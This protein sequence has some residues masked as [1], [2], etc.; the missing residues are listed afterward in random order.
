MELKENIHQNIEDTFKVLDAIKEVKV[1]HF[2]KD[3]VLQQYQNKQEK[4]SKV[5][6]WFQPQLQLAALCLVLLLNASALFYA[7]SSED[8]NTDNTL[9]NFAQEYALQSENTSILN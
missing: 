2:F 7:Y 4:N 8:S 5:A 1:N 6:L 3:K 9:E